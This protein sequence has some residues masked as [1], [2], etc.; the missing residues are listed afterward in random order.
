MKIPSS[1]YST[2]HCGYSAK[3]RERESSVVCY[4]TKYCGKRRKRGRGGME[5]VWSQISFCG[6]WLREHECQFTATDCTAYCIFCKEVGV[7]TGGRVYVYSMQCRMLQ[8]NTLSLCHCCYFL[9]L[10][11]CAFVANKNQQSGSSL[12]SLFWESMLMMLFVGICE[13]KVLKC[14]VDLCLFLMHAQRFLSVHAS[15]YTQPN[16]VVFRKTSSKYIFE[17]K[18]RYNVWMSY[19]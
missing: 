7:F 4:L 18:C 10:L 9:W 8:K 16:A 3:G 12:L 15:T 5:M 6:E 19:R 11:L 17:L 2:V 14:R 13:R 1:L